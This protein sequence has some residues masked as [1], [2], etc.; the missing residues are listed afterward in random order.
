[1]S[2]AISKWIGVDLLR[3]LWQ[4]HERRSA[5]PIEFPLCALFYNEFINIF[6]LNSH[7]H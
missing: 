3:D 5:R 1:M 7:F 6:R 2:D 4:I